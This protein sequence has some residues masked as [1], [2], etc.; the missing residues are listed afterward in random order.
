MIV[1][2]DNNITTYEY[3]KNCVVKIRK[4]YRDGLYR[5]LFEYGKQ[6]KLVA[7][8]SVWDFNI[9]VYY[10]RL[11]HLAFNYIGFDRNFE[12]GDICGLVYGIRNYLKRKN[13]NT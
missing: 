7:D 10:S 12:E 5:Y 1:T 4:I 8:F 6:D 2:I 3:G 9:P 13:K 11:I